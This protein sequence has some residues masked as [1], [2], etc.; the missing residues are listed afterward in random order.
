MAS[1]SLFSSAAER[2]CMKD[3]G[4]FVT[5][6]AVPKSTSTFSVPVSIARFVSLSVTS[7][8][9]LKGQPRLRMCKRRQ[10]SWK[11]SSQTT[12]SGV[13]YHKDTRTSKV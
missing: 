6:H 4:H 1:E 13:S 11:S 5:T 12:I 10:D 9:C 3:P 7:Q 8:N 2:T